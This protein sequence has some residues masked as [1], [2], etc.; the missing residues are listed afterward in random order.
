M[1]VTLNIPAATRRKIDRD[2][3]LAEQ[4][5]AVLADALSDAANVGADD[6]REQL[7][8]GQLGLTMQ[9]PES[10]MAAQLEGWMPDRNRF[11]AYIGIRG[12]KKAALQAWKLEHG[13]DIFP[14]NAKLLAVPISDEAKRHTSPRDMEGL[15]LIPRKG[16]PPLL[17][18]Q[19]TRR[20]N[21]RGFELHWVLV[22][23]V[24][25]EPRYWLSRGA[26]HATGA[27]RDMFAARMGRFAN[28]W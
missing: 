22:P 14:K 26:R 4:T 18:R 5:G 27:M 1:I 25:I 13:G 3:K 28:D 12:E 17:V 2:G 21:L 11:T 16:K 20:G 19:L 23:R 7:Q 6:V 8:R 9:H 24:H 15:D 10:G